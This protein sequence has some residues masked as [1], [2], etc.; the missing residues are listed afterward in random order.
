MVE[1]RAR[2]KIPADELESKRGR[3]L[4]DADY[5]VLLTRAA[6]VRQPDGRLLCVYLPGVLKEATDDAYDLLTTIRMKSDNRGLAAGSVRVKAGSTRTR[7]KPV[8]SGIL[9]SIDPIPAAPFCRLTAYTAKQVDKWEQLRPLFQAMAGEFEANV[10]DRYA[11]Q[12][13]Y[14]RQTPP[15]WIIPGTPYTTITINNSYPTGVHTDRG[16]LDAGFSCLG[17]ARR[18]EFTGGFL[19]FPEYRVAVDMQDGDMLLMDAHQWH[20]NTKMVCACGEV[21]D[22]P[23]RTCGAERISVVAYYR[24]EMKACDSLPAERQKA[25]EAHEKRVTKMLDAE[26]ADAQAFRELTRT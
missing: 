3:I 13:D 4:T 5:N 12:M 25:A 7:A 6:K 8:Y 9:G 19:T 22:G 23:C 11:A 17:V 10:G 2:T 26:S 14:V 18:G 20:G 24:T 15:D 1:L 21:V 16:D